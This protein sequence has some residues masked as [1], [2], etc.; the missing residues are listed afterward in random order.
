M[1]KLRE[2][3][4]VQF[5][6]VGFVVMV[7]VAV[8]LAL[9]LSNII[10][11]NAI[12]DLVDEAVGTSKGRLLDV[13]TPADFE[14]PMTAER[15]DRFHEFVQQSIVSE[16]TARIKVVRVGPKEGTIIYSDDRSSVGKTFPPPTPLLKALRGETVPI[17]RIP[18]DVAHAAERELGTLM[19]VVTP[20]IFPGTTEPPGVSSGPHHQDSGEA[21]IR[22]S[23]AGVSRKP[24]SD[25]KACG[26]SSKHLCGLTAWNT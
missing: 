16:R 17:L 13:I 9:V 18:E 22:E 12:D 2:N 25:C 15:Y 3:L 19:E 7:T 1:S 20:I 26:C 11:S 4:L 6:V 10:R 21:K 23:T 24:S 14:A 5:S 8:V